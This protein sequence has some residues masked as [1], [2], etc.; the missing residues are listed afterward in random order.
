MA[1]DFKNGTLLVKINHLKEDGAEVPLEIEKDLLSKIYGEV[2][3]LSPYR[4]QTRELLYMY[5]DELIQLFLDVKQDESMNKE[6]VAVFETLLLALDYLTD[7]RFL[8]VNFK[9]E[10]RDYVKEVLQECFNVKKK[11]YFPYQC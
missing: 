4:H 7:P 1:Q 3:L 10:Y 9:R 11:P 6:V 5:T 2:D 8:K